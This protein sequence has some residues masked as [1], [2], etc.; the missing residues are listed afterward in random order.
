MRSIEDDASR[1]LVVALSPTWGRLK[2]TRAGQTGIDMTEEAD[3]VARSRQ[4]CHG[5]L[6]LLR[7]G[8]NSIFIT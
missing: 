6:L 7:Y 4:E 3:H 5:K 2:A 1:A 8:S